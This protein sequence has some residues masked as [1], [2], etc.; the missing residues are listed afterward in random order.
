MTGHAIGPHLQLVP[1]C[2]ST[3][4]EGALSAPTQAFVRRVHAQYATGRGVA[5]CVREALTAAAL[6]ASAVPPALQPARLRAELVR[7]ATTYP[8]RRAPAGIAGAGSAAAVA[9]RSRGVVTELFRV[10]RAAETAFAP[11]I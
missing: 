2:S 7:I 9:L 1:T 3:S 10:V 8:A 11:G 5:A 4:R 6:A